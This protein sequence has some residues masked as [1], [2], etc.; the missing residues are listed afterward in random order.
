MLEIQG[1]SVMCHLP[2][3]ACT[4]FH[5]QELL[6]GEKGNIDEETLARARAMIARDLDDAERKKRFDAKRKDFDG[7]RREDDDIL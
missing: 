4:G 6:E 2:E 1:L 7:N 3:R 5:F